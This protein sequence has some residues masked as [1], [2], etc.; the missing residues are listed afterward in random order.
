VINA[1]V[2]TVRPAADAKTIRISV[3][4]DYGAGMVLGDSTRLQQI[5]WNLLSN[6]VKFTPRDGSVKISLERI[7][8][9][10]EI[11]VGRQRYR[12]EET[13][14]AVC[15]RSLSARRSERE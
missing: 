9:H 5:I 13:F 6:A 10:V 3:V 1:A 7:N 14:S 12:I 4:L 11:I 2:E 8:S 15:F